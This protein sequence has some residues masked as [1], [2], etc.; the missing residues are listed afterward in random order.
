[1]IN[2]ATMGH[3][4]YTATAGKV[5]NDELTRF[6]RYLA[7]DVSYIDAFTIVINAEG[8]MER[9]RKNWL[10]RKILWLDGDVG[11]DT[12]LN[13]IVSAVLARGIPVS[14]GGVIMALEDTRRTT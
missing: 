4:V 2:K 10:L 8:L 7:R 12:V 14:K 3:D 9:F 11:D 1:M 5:I 13:L 6:L